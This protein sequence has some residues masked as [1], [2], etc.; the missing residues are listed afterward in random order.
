MNIDREVVLHIAKLAHIELQESEIELFTKQLGNILHYIET[1]DEVAEDAPPF[2][3]SSFL[4]SKMRHDTPQPSLPI[5][6][7]LR[8][9]PEHVKRF[10][11]VPKVLP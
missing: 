2:S 3:Y 6:E 11:K 5:E 10:F 8:N 1:I 7:T 4:P 9:A